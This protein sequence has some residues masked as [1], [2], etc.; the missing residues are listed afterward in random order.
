LHTKLVA[1]LYDNL[2]T[3]KKV[4]IFGKKKKKYFSPKKQEKKQKSKKKGK[5]S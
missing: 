1:I 5:K 4:F 3:G 2:E